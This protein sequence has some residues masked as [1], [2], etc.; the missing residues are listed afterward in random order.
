MEKN[1]ENMRLDHKFLHEIISAR[2]EQI[3]SKI[4]DQLIQIN[5][6]GKLAGGVHLT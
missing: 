6:D 5:R 2:Y 1:D 4:N 3:F